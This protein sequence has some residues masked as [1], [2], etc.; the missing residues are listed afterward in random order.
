MQVVKNSTWVL[1]EELG[2]FCL[3]QNTLYGSAS[4]WVY[5]KSNSNPEHEDNK[6]TTKSAAQLSM[7]EAIAAM[8]KNKLGRDTLLTNRQQMNLLKKL[9]RNY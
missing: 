4:R 8:I 9:G 7:R 6:F 3:Y 1:L 5:C 2:C